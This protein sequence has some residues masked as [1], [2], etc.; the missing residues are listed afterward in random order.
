LLERLANPGLP[1]EGM[2]RASFVLADMNG[3]G[4][5]DVV[6]PPARIG[7]EPVPH[8]FL[9]DGKGR[10]QRWKLTFV[11]EDGKPDAGSVDYGAVAAGDIDGDGKMDIV[12]ASHG[13]GLASFFGDGKGGFRVVRRGLPAADFSSQSIVLLD[14]DGDGRLDIA[15]G[16][17]VVEAKDNEPIDTKQVRVYLFRGNEGWK[18]AP[19]ALDGGFYS[20]SLHAWDSDGDGRS[21]LLT[22]S[23]Y[24][25][26]L[27]LLWKNARG[28]FLP[29]SFPAIEI[30]AYHFAT[31][32]G[33]FGASRRPAFADSFYI[34]DPAPVP[35]RKATGITIYE[36]TS[37][38]WVRHRVWRKKDG[39][40]QQYALAFGDLD[41]DGLDDI[42]FPDSD[43]NRLRVMFQSADGGFTE[44]AETQ[45]P[46]L[47]S[48]GQCVRLGDLDGDG[49]LDVVLAR[50]VVS[51]RPDDRGGF[52]VY[53]NRPA[54]P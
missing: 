24:A 48:V 35:P 46:E 20:N 17:D 50:T 54:K 9:G 45:E 12:S 43:R 36:N 21:D 26:A 40:T 42:V 53:L 1:A 39:G 28:R 22:G 14:A 25:G 37:T 32:P 38:G 49:R 51:F 3:D 15:A 44:L 4:K 27:S 18:F 11:N 19:E 7:P 8:V 33:T 16:R 41:G 5:L 6:A 23:H 30:Y 2:W 10:F 31:A 13:N 34:Y 29:V 47:D 52:E